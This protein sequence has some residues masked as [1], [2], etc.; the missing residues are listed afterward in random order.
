MYDSIILSHLQF[1]ITCWGF[2]CTRISKLQKRALRIMTLSK[3]NAHTDPLFKDLGLLKIKD[4]FDLQC[5]KFWFKFTNGSLPKFFRSVF[6]Y[7]HE[8]YTITTRSHD[9]LH[10]FPTRTG[11]ARLILR[12]Y[13]PEL[14]Y[15]FSDDVLGKVHTHSMAGFVS[16]VKSHMIDRYDFDCLVPDCFVCTS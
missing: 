6:R 7:N 15:D 13:I 14:L 8:I 4:I 9:R 16:H 5:M 12:H 1:G 10:L 11:G 2:E 3:Y